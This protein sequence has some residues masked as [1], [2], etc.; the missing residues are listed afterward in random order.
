MTR[1]EAFNLGLKYFN[2]GKPCKRGHMLDRY[3]GNGACIGCL[4]FPLNHKHIYN[5]VENNSIIV[6]LYAKEDDLELI[7][8][9]ADCYIAAKFPTVKPEDINPFPFK[10]SRFVTKGIYRIKVRVPFEN[11]LDIEKLAA[12]I[13]NLEPPGF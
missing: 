12:H 1:R 5:F 8:L 7:K 13:D 9:A 10:G 3:V 2:T 4:R 11:A 6:K